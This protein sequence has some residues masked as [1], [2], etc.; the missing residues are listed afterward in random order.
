MLNN[1]LTTRNRSLSPEDIRI[2][3]AWEQSFPVHLGQYNCYDYVTSG[4]ERTPQQHSLR[5]SHPGLIG[6]LPVQ[7][8]RPNGQ[9]GEGGI[10]NTSEFRAALL[11]DGCV[12]A[13]CCEG[14]P[15]DISGHYLI[16]AFLD[17]RPAR[18]DYHFFRRDWGVWS[19]K[20]SNCSVSRVDASEMPIVDPR[21]A[22]LDYTKC[23]INGFRGER[24]YGV[25]V[26]FFYV[27][28][29]GFSRIST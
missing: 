6:D 28:S 22:D 16:A 14:M 4:Q 13:E 9:V 7:R 27:P 18:P 2:D 15:K 24:I 5:P 3:K 25:F 19:H 17:N 11:K 12:A 8:R 23:I 20:F 21:K 26:G 10:F 1:G 29:A